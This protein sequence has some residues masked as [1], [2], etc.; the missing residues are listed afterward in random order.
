MS[1]YSRLKKEVKVGLEA[2]AEQFPNLYKG[3][4]KDLMVNDFV[5]DIPLGTAQNILDYYIANGGELHPNHYVLNIY[6]LFDDEI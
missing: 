1:L 4:V 5:T 2:D 3:I 6:N